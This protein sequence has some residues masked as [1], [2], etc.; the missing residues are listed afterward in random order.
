MP[1]CGGYCAPCHPPPHLSFDLA[2]GAG[3]GLDRPQICRWTVLRLPSPVGLSAV[4]VLSLRKNWGVVA[5][6]VLEYR[7]ECGCLQ[8]VRVPVDQVEPAQITGTVG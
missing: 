5:M 7:L 8:T 1:P 4:A 3:K 6:M 2:S